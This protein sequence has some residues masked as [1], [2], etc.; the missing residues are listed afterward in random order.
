[1][2]AVKKKTLFFRAWN[3][4]NG[5]L[6]FAPVAQYVPRVVYGVDPVCFVLA[7]SENLEK[8]LYEI[9]LVCIHR[10]NVFS[11]RNNTMRI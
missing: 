8:P 5:F 7:K 11:S 1:M 3:L 10:K 2:H 4:L 6:R 9:T